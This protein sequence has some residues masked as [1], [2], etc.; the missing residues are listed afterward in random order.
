MPALQEYRNA[1]LGWLFYKKSYSV[2]EFSESGTDREK[3]EREK[4][5]QLKLQNYNDTIIS[6][7][8]EEERTNFENLRMI[9]VQ[10][11]DS[12]EILYPGLLTGSGYTHETGK[13]GEFKIGF[14]FDHTTGLPVLPGH[15]VKGVIRSG[16]PQYHRGSVIK[17]Q[18]QKQDDLINFL[19]DGLYGCGIDTEKN[20]TAYL[21]EI[22]I[23]KDRPVYSDKLFISMLEKNIFDGLVPEV[24]DGRWEKDKNGKEIFRPLGIYERDIFFDGCL[25]KG[26]SKGLFLAT[27]SITPHPSPLENPN[28]LL[29]LKI[30]SGVHIQFQFDT[31]DCLIKKENKLKLFRFLI[32][33]TGIGAKT[34]VGYGQFADVGIKYLKQ[35]ERK[36]N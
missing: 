8:Y 33:T 21:D 5:N 7:K 11:P 1:N 13:L 24:K 25:V 2:I 15:S 26:D 14:Y 30:R 19:K 4:N 22:N 34:N 35:L 17:Y 36:N 18:Q 16:F 29:F 23:T 27:D 10:M 9:G 12:M 6:R 28:P 3:K 31:K 32:I 20:F